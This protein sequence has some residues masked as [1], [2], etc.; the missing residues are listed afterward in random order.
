[1]PPLIDWLARPWD[2]SVDHHIAP[3]LAWHGRLMVAGWAIL[4]P[5]GVLAAR[6][7]KL[8]PGQD[9]PTELDDQHWWKA[10]RLLLGVGI[11]A[12]T[13]GL[14]LAWR[15]GT[16]VAGPTARSHALLGW[17]LMLLG[18]SQVVGGVLRGTKGGPT[19]P[20]AGPGGD[21]YAMT[22]RR[23]LFEASHKAGGW[24]AL[25]LSLAAVPSGLALASAPRWMWLAIGGWWL[26]LAVVAARLQAAGRCIDTY[27]AIWGPGPDLPGNRLRPIGWGIVRRPET[28][29]R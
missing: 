1:M 29:Q 14:W 8:W 25:A 20:R 15:H 13:G 26:A 5:L 19:D 16:A 28:P 9:W 10:H 3:W 22:R 11:A 18:W 21:H 2:G 27:Q 12:A 23:V 4:A 7:F 24:A 17:A 6:Y